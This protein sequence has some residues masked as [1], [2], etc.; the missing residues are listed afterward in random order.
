M[1]GVIYSSRVKTLAALKS[2]DEAAAAEAAAQG[3]VPGYCGDRYF[4]AAA[5]GQYCPKFD[6]R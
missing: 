2:D 1:D 3:G 6:A 4:R 5:G